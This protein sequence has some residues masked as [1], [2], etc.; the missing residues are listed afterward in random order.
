[1]QLESPIA[2]I[3]ETDQQVGT[4]A[5]Q[6]SHHRAAQAPSATGNEQILSF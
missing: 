6:E 5:G 3:F 4:I 2:I 1:L